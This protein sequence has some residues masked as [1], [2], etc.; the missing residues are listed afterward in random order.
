MRKQDQEIIKELCRVLTVD[1][2]CVCSPLRD[3]HAT[4]HEH[5]H[6]NQCR[7]V[8]AAAL[9]LAFLSD[10]YEVQTAPRSGHSPKPPGLSKPDPSP[11]PP[12]SEGLYPPW[13][14]D[15]PRLP[16]PP[17]SE[18]P[19]H[20]IRPD[21]EAEPSGFMRSLKVDDLSTGG[22][23]FPQSR[24]TTLN[25]PDQGI[26]V[27]DYVAT[28]AL[29]CFSLGL[30]KERGLD[31]DAVAAFCYDVGEAFLAERELRFRRSAPKA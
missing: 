18:Q 28:Q 4:Q 3:Q 20:R 5:L 24:V 19:G 15:M 12:K 29:T 21:P 10:F 9:K 16:L 11:A 31:S 6:S 22:P 2:G 7:A 27:L 13:P 25:T 14:D 8:K 1:V 17:L 23:A 30:V 26:T